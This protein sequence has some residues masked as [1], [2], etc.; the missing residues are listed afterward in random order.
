MD[1]KVKEVTG[2]EDKSVAQIEEQLLKKH[3]EKMEGAKPEVNVVEP[4]PEAVE[5]VES[6]TPVP[7]TT[8]LN[9]EDVLSYIKDRYNKEITSVDELL[10]QREQNEELPEDV[11]AFFEYKKNTGRNI[12]DF[13]NLQKDYDEMGDDQI[14]AAYYSQTEEGLDSSDIKELIDDSF[15]YEEDYDDEKDIKKRRL[16][17]KREL[18]KARKFLNEQKEQYN[19]PLESSG[20]VRSD[21]QVE[22]F[23]RYKSYIDE[24]NNAKEATKKR[25]D[26]FL[27]KTEEV[28]N[29]D[30]KGFDFKVGESSFT[31]KPGDATELKNLQS[32]VNNFIGKYMDKESGLMN[33]PKGYHRSMSVAMNPEKFA[34]FFYDQGMAAAV[35]NVSKKSKN[36]NMEMRNA[37]QARTKDGLTIRSLSEPSKK[38]LTIK[39][40]KNR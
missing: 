27:Q 22:E 26:Y 28:F 19:V 13:M 20:K 30:F 34:Q 36:I 38:G 16:A 15:G 32:D 24:A 7:E 18:S 12:S 31:F 14:L 29:N 9:D 25:Y 39:S 8:P 5:K 35:D 21:E 17:K 33:D 4:K 3:E 6:S 11:K 10:A 37:P 23:N 1:F 2:V 40:N